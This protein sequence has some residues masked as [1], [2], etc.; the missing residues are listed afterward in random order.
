[1]SPD[2]AK[3]GRATLFTVVVPDEV[4]GAAT[5]GVRIALPASFTLDRGKT[6]WHGINRDQLRLR[7]TATPRNGGDFALPVTQIY[8]DGSVVRWSG[9][10]NANTPAPV[11]HVQGRENASRDR[12]KIL[13]IVLAVGVLGLALRV[14]RRQR[15]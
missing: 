4:A 8:S 3:A 1:M 6:S 7:L 5:T 12:L 2:V 15:P 9:P 14:R 10:E 11:V 13:A